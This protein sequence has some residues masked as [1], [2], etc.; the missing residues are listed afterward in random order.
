M[1]VSRACEP[2]WTDASFVDMGCLF[3][4]TT[5]VHYWEANEFC[6][7]EQTAGLM[8]LDTREQLEYISLQLQ[9][10]ELQ[11]GQQFTWWAGGSDLGR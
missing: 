7:W 3:F 5:L 10:L 6:R 1:D 11:M 8:E 2:G 4:N 9:L